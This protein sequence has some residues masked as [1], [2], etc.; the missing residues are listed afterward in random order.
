ILD[1]L[2]VGDGIDQGFTFVHDRL[3]SYFREEVLGDLG[4]ARWRKHFVDWGAHVVQCL[5]IGEIRP[6]DVSEYLVV[7][8]SEHLHAAKAP[9]NA[10]RQLFSNSW[11]EVAKQLDSG[12]SPF[13]LDSHPAIE[14]PANAGQLD[15]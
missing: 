15:T 11:L 3:R 2:L 1:R 10:Y 6:E 13:L 8:Y 14:S 9:L 12:L 5:S 4:V 7:H